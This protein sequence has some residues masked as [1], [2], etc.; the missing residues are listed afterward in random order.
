MCVLFGFHFIVFLCTVVSQ[1]SDI[2]PRKSYLFL[3]Y[4]T[5]TCQIG[6]LRFEN[7]AYHRFGV[8]KMS[9]N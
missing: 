1:Y 9:S 7:S 3:H 5:N 6:S 8:S 4:I 2:M